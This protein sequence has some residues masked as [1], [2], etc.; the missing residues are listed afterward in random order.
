MTAMPAATS[1]GA[2][3]AATV[4]RAGC[5]WHTSIT[6]AGSKP[7]A[8]AHADQAPTTASSESTSTPSQSK[9]IAS[10]ARRMAGV[11]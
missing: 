5:P 8:T 4:A 11:S 1:D 10:G 2:R 6:A 7:Y 3:K 9:T